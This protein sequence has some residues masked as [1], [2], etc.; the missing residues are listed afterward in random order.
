MK[1]SKRNLALVI[2]LALLA[3][4]CSVTCPPAPA[5]PSPVEQARIQG[6][7]AVNSEKVVIDAGSA[8]ARENTTAMVRGQLR[9]VYVDYATVTATTDIT[10][11][12]K[13]A[14]TETIL[15]LNNNVTDGWYYPRRQVCDKD[16]TALTYD[17]TYA[18]SEPFWVDDYLVAV[19][20]GTTAL[21]P[22][23]TIYYFWQ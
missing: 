14:P 7:I 8:T 19:V 6:A 18:V 3:A 21:T 12:A 20:D 5:C 16:G 17:G 9:A 22:C 11:S 4:A 1:Q 10:I 23:V 2:A 13:S 15:N